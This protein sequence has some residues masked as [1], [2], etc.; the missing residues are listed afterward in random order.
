[1]YFF[2]LFKSRCHMAPYPFNQWISVL[3]GQEQSLARTPKSSLSFDC[4]MKLFNVACSQGERAVESQA[5]S[6]EK[7][8]FLNFQSSLYIS[9]I[10]NL[11]GFLLG[12]GAHKSSALR[13]FLRF[14]LQPR[15]RCICADFPSLDVKFSECE[16]KEADCGPR[17]LGVCSYF[18]PSRSHCFERNIPRP[19]VFYS[20]F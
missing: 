17:P 8:N 1:M 19:L 14:S 20:P 11:I 12:N 4:Q 6:R 5:T 9:F 2:I 18:L 13:V 3:Q 10:S 7:K 16:S 15:T